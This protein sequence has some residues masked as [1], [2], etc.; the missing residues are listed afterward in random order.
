MGDKEKTAQAPAGSPPP[1]L[2]Y[3]TTGD[4]RPTVV[5]PGPKAPKLTRTQRFEKRAES[6]ASAGRVHGVASVQEATSVLKALPAEVKLVR[7]FFVG[8]GLD[9][10]Y[11]L[12]GKPDPRADFEA[13]S[14][15]EI[16]T[17]PAEVSDAAI[18]AQHVQFLDELAKHLS[19]T[20]RLEIGFLACFA[21]TKNLISSYCSALDKRGF[22]NFVVGGYK[23]DYETQFVFDQATG[24]ILKWTDAI[25]D[26]KD[27]KKTLVR[28][29]NNQIPPYEVKCHSSNPIDPLDI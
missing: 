19:T 7:V 28:M 24:K 23:N 2:C 27:T 26:R 8:H 29:D 12:H 11:F 21:A 10:G 18:K 16:L 3:F 5:A 6:L 22:R 4:T 20:Q 1:T 13:A 15:A 9:D 14:D 25:F 17:N